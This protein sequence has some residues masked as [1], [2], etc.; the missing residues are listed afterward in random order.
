MAPRETE[1]NAYAKFWG[2]KERALW[3]VMVFSGVVNSCT[4]H[5]FY[6]NFFLRILPREDAVARNLITAYNFSSQRPHLNY[7]FLSNAYSFDTIEFSMKN[8][9]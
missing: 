7:L 1:N 6:T 4:F 2:D 5:T 3:Y 8:K 9:Y